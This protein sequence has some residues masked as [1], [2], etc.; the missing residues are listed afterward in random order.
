MH[1]SPERLAATVLVDGRGWILLQERDEHAPR[2]PNQWGLVGGHADPG[3]D[4]E[5]AVHREL[6]EETG[7]RCPGLRLWFA[8]EIRRSD[9]T[10]ADHY[11]VWVARTDATDDD[12]VLGEGRRIV[13]ADP[14]RLGELD[15]GDSASYLLP[16][17]LA[18]PTYAALTADQFG[19]H[20]RPWQE[21]RATPWAR[22]RYALVA[23]TLRR[24]LA[25]AGRRRVLDVGGGDAADS[26]PLAVAGHDVTVLD[27]SP[28][29]LA[30]ACAA[31]ADAGVPLRVVQGSLADLEP[32]GAYDVVLCHF[33]LQ[34]RDDTVAD[35]ARLAGA[36]RPGGLISLIAPNPDGAVLATM[37]RDGPQTALERIGAGSSRTQVF[38]TEVRDIGIDEARAALRAAGCTP[39]AL[40]GGRIVNDLVADNRAKHDPAWY[41]DLLRL[42]LALHDLEPFNRIGVY[43][44]LLASRD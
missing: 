19:E 7:L 22:L 2:S 38:D 15:L 25:G 5:A 8:G 33:L 29:M 24:R 41:E 32:T 31:A 43:W 39:V 28:A 23:Q 13:F 4:F 6:A 21:Y 12:I 16:R 44:H 11:Q 1:D 34:Y 40:L 14:A 3:E 10:A 27:T 20:Q 30:A 42:E 36:L 37:V 9:R 18:S 17:F 35:V 26:L